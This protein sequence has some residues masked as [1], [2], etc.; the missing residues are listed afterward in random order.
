MRNNFQL[1][2]KLSSHLHMDPVARTNKL[3]DFMSKL[4]S[5]KVKA[6]FEAWN[7]DFDSVPITTTARVL[8][9][10]AVVFANSRKDLSDPT[11]FEDCQPDVK[12][13]WTRN[14]RSKL[15]SIFFTRSV[16]DIF[17]S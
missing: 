2:K 3:K 17:C 5:P 15:L 7:I 8:P 11:R 13:D 6:E 16:S 12:G 14:M 10:Q 9:Q 4:M 1:M